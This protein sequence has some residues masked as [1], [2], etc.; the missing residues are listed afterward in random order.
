MV[1][2]APA[3]RAQVEARPEPPFHRLL[4]PWTDEVVRGGPLARERFAATWRDRAALETL[5]QV[6]RS[7]LPRPL[8]EGL[9]AMHVGLSASRESLASLEQL[10]RGEAVCAV[11]GQQPAPLGGPLYALHKTAAAVGLARQIGRA[12]V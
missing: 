10:A 6:K 3:I 11:A 5:V 2:R 12:H 4:D 1:T 7:A 9:R 8:A